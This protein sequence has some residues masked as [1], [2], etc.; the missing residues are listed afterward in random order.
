M[1]AAA[2]G[3]NPDAHASTAKVWQSDIVQNNLTVKPFSLFLSSLV[4]ADVERKIQMYRG[5]N[6][7]DLNV[8]P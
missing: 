6:Q 5:A 2:S 3:A 4:T 1:V 8:C 7:H